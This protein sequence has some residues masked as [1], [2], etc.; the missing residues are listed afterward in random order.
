MAKQDLAELYQVNTL[1][2]TLMVELFLLAQ[3]KNRNLLIK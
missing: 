2:L 3:L 1:Q